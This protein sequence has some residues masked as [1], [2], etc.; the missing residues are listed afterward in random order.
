MVNKETFF[1]TFMVISYY[2]IVLKAMKQCEK[3]N[4]KSLEA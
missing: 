3:K 2:A 1:A 4:T